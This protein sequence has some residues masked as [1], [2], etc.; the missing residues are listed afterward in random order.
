MNQIR[1]TAGKGACATI[2]FLLGL[3]STAGSC[4]CAPESD[5]SVQIARYPTI[6][7]GQAV[8]DVAEEPAR[9]EAVFR[10]L[11]VWK[12]ERSSTLHVQTHR[13]PAACGVIFYAKEYYVVFA[14]PE[15]GMLATDKCTPTQEA[16]KAGP[17]IRALDTQFH[18]KTA[19]PQAEERR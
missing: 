14:Y 18:V 17:V 12:G 9:V 5:L 7:L 19:I 16:S 11:Q 15:K 13:Q 6:F 8:D 4:T 2:V 10:V 1:L 3:P